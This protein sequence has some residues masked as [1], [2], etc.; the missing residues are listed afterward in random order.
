MEATTHPLSLRVRTYLREMFP[1]FTYLPYV[2]ALY[3]C[4][5]FSAQALSGGGIVIDIHAIV[6]MISAFFWMLLMRTFDDLKDFDLDKDLFPW[7]ATAR[8]AVLRGD[9]VKVSWLSFLVLVATNVA[10]GQ[11]TLLVFG[12]V[13]LYCL[14]TFQWFGFEKFHREHIYFTMVTH[15]PIPYSINLF[16]IYTGLA[17][18]PEMSAFTWNHFYLLLIFSLPVT[19][20]EVSRKIRGVG[21]ETHYET[22]SLLLGARTAA[23]IPLVA[24]LGAAGLSVH[25][26]GYL[27][28]HST[29][30]YNIAALVVVMAV[31]YVRFLLS[32][33]KKN[34]VLTK[35]AMAYTSLL[36]VNVV[37]HIVL[38]TPISVAL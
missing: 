26:A 35:V 7:R 11:D 38:I 21:H 32:P 15:Q 34:N 2:I 20:W 17:S 12:L 22:F 28:L 13:M 36:F 9:I 4:L 27:E 19:A 10:L 31:F 5:N 16:L 24:L 8:G 29:C 18:G 6:G 14:G 3:A 37:V 30:Y 23:I 33:T 25:I 1:V